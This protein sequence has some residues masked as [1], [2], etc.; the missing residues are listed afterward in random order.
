MERFSEVKYLPMASNVG[1]AVANNA[2]VRMA[3]GE[4][5]IILNS[6]ITAHRGAIEEL[7]R[8][9]QSDAT[10]GIVSPRLLN[11]DGTVQQSYFRFYTPLTVLAR[12][13]WFGDTPWGKRLIARALMRD[14]LIKEVAD[15]DWCLAACFCMRKAVWE[16]LGGMDERFFLYFEDIDL[17]RRVWQRGYRVQ[18]VPTITLTH[19]YGHGSA[20]RAGIRALLN[21]LTRL[22]IESGIRY[23]FKHGWWSRV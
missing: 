21:P 4:T 15:V 11:P 22:H 16:E 1:F 12:R 9:V 13:T 6:D 17:A 7:V 23:F 3:H 18:Y 10:L 2:G 20:G 8:R 5:V 19:L 14:A